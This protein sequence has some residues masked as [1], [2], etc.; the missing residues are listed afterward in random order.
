MDFELLVS[1]IVFILLYVL[2]LVFNL[3]IFYIIFKTIVNAF[4]RKKIT[5]Y[6][7]NNVI[8]YQENNGKNSNGATKFND[9]VVYYQEIN[10]KSSKFA[11]NYKDVSKDKLA[12]FN[13]DDID[14][15]KEYFYQIFYN[16]EIA[17]NNLDYSMMKMLSIEQLYQNYYTGISLDLK[18]GKKRVISDIKKKKIILYELDT[19]LIKQLASLV[20]EVS[21]Y[22]YTLDKNGYVI[23]GSRYE[24]ITEKFEVEFRK[25]YDGKNLTHCPNC[26]ASLSTHKCD[27]CKATIKESEFKISSIKRIINK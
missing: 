24:P 17:Y 11:K 1:E 4:R 9:D 27:Y 19:T 16:F 26:G 5:T 18:T 3:A 14:S 23:S 13:T 25:Y 20:I 8:Y 2:Q 6:F 7:K 22:N 15:L 10:G 12:K 21:Y